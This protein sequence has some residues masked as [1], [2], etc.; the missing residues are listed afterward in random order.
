MQNEQIAYLDNFEL[1]LTRNLL[2]IA[3]DLRMGGGQLYQ[4]DDL[5]SVWN[6]IAP[7]YM[8]DAVPNIPQ[9]PTVSLAW[10]GYIGMA[11]ADIWDKDWSRVQSSD[12]V[13]NMLSSPRGF[14][15]M[16]EYIVEEIL[17]MPSES[18][19]AKSIEHLMLSISRAALDAIRHEQVEPQSELAFHVYARSVRAVF[20]IGASCQL[21]LLGYKWQKIAPDH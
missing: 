13:Y 17:G 4:S 9:Y 16:D 7:Y 1:S 5:D 15:R 19:G 18:S 6:D 3:H 11:L 8:Q 21:Y 2:A 10:A 14:D 12:S 20:R